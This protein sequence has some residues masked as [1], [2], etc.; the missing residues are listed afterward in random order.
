MR[1]LSAFSYMKSAPGFSLP[2]TR[3]PPTRAKPASF[4]FGACSGK[5]RRFDSHRTIRSSSLAPSFHGAIGVRGIER[6]RERRLPLK[7]RRRSSACCSTSPAK[8]PPRPTPTHK[9]AAAAKAIVSQAREVVTSRRT[10]GRVAA[11]MSFCGSGSASHGSS[12]FAVSCSGAGSRS[13]ATQARA[14][15]PGRRGRAES[16]AARARRPRRRGARLR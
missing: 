6:V 16:G 10:R 4:R 2:A 14:R 12:A 1:C 15:A 8:L 9:D 7:S 13:R 11:S 3:R 5:L